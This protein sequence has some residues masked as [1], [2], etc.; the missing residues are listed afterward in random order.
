MTLALDGWTQPTTHEKVV[1]FVVLDGNAAYFWKSVETQ[2]EANTGEYLKEKTSEV[3]KEIEE[4]KGIVI[5]VCGDN[6][7][8]SMKKRT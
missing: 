6:V 4:R 1:N 2:D 8:K 5:A 7:G 3:I